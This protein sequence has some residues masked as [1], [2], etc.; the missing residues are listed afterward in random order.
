MTEG[1]MTTLD[2]L[3]AGRRRLAIFTEPVPDEAFLPHVD[4]GALLAV[5]RLCRAAG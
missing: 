2:D 4:C 1:T 5:R 3:L